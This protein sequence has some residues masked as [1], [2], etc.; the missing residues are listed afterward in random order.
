M[1]Q[2][3]LKALELANNIMDFCPGDKW[4]RE[5]TAADREQF[6]KLYNEILMKES[7]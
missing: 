1:K 3:M 2:K 5:C 7:R 6:E 4:E